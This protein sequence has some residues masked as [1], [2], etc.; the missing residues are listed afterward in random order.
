MKSR[1]KNNHHSRHD[2]VSREKRV[3]GKTGLPPGSL[4]HIGKV[5]TD[6]VQVN[7]TE[8]NSDKIIHRSIGSL[9]GLDVMDDSF[10]SW[11][12]IRGL[13]DTKVIESVGQ[14]LGIN[15]LVLEDILNTEHRPKFDVQD[16]L[17]FL[18]L[19]AFSLSANRKIQSEQASFVLGKGFLVSFQESNHSWFDP[20]KFRLNNSIGKIR[21]RG[22]DFI[23]YSLID[24]IVDQYYA[25]AEE[26]SDQ[27]EELEEMIFENPSRELLEKIRL[28]K[29]E[30]ITI[31]KALTPLLEAISKLNR[32]EPDLIEPEVRRYYDDVYDH[33]VQIID[34]IDTYRELSTE[35]KE[36]YLSNLTLRMNQVM[37]LLTIITT[38]FIPLT[39][40][41]GIYGMNFENMPELYWQ[42][43]YFCILAI[44]FII[45]A[46][47]LI[48]FRRK[49][50]I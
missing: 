5:L 18:T 13:H 25:V 24:V 30:I 48:Y 4:I 49:K 44:M 46:G 45:M 26:I 38:I 20:V 23:L 35:L 3:S 29:K 43:G 27:L 42:Y 12:E 28:I 33:I 11:I 50:W 8:F 47:M 41:A 15:P 36:S 14:T 34:Y 9:D 22:L 2:P 19:K 16:G 37:K 7:L 6:S 10:N 32:D 17:I 40:I 31:R 1:K 39:F 21:H